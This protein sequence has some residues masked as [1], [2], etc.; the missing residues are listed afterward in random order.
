MLSWMLLLVLLFFS[1]SSGLTDSPEA[2]RQSLS[3]CHCLTS[4]LSSLARATCF[5]RTFW[6]WFP[7]VL[8]PLCSLA[9]ISS[10]SNSW[11]SWCFSSSLIL[12]RWLR[13]SPQPPQV[14]NPPADDGDVAFS[15]RWKLASLK[16]WMQSRSTASE[17]G[18]WPTGGLQLIRQRWRRMQ[19]VWAN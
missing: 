19:G 13:L 15:S 18:H 8:P 4:L 10:S 9:F 1:W 3:T 16:S 12:I 7:L 2:A 17:D 11:F 14:S 5:L 6:P